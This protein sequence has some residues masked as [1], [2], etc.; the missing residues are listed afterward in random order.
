MLSD[1]R[2]RTA[3]RQACRRWGDARE[4]GSGRR[5][6]SPLWRTRRVCVIWPPTGRGL[7]HLGSRRPKLSVDHGGIWGHRAPWGALCRALQK[8]TAQRISGLGLLRVPIPGPL[9]DT[10]PTPA[11][12]GAAGLPRGRHPASVRWG[13]GLRQKRRLFG[14]ARVSARVWG[15]GFRPAFGDTGETFMGKRFCPSAHC[16]ALRPSDHARLDVGTLR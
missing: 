1:R 14:E 6:L 13:I 7:R 2:G 15:R 16:R 5:V 12:K 9:C 10:Q 4:S 3:N 8:R 11:S